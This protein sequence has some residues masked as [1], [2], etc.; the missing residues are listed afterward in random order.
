MKIINF[1]FVT[2][3]G[4]GSALLEALRTDYPLAFIMTATVTPFSQ[5]ESPLQHFNSLLSLSWL[6]SYSDAVLLFG[7]DS[8]LQ[9]VQ[10]GLALADRAG[11]SGREKLSRPGGGGLSVEDMNRHISS[12]L[13]NTLMPVWKQKQK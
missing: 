10:R 3:V 12:V 9:Q 13:C 1:P 11:L 8:L 2:T 7:N 5:G 4:L 6:Q